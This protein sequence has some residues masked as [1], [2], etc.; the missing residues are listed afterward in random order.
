MII[1]TSCQKPLSSHN[2]GF[3][4]LYEFCSCH[5]SSFFT[6][7]QLLKKS[8]FLHGYKICMQCLDSS[9]DEQPQ[10]TISMKQSLRLCLPRQFITTFLRDVYRLKCLVDYTMA[11]SLYHLFW[12]HKV[13]KLFTGVL[14]LGI[15]LNFTCLQVSY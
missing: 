14:W 1:L 4:K 9:V 13:C 7:H 3:Y 8:V 15:I 2:V 5:N 11:C 6:M 12:T 10:G